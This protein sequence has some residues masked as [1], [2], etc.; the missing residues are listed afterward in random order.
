QAQ[1]TPGRALVDGARYIR[2]WGETVR[3]AARVHTIGGLSAHAGQDS[4]FAWYQ[5]FGGPPPVALVHGEPDASQAL[6]GLLRRGGAA[7]VT[8]PSYGDA[9]ELAELPTSPHS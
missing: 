7:R 2:L 5:Q 1:G 6:A 9:I 4:L 8:I 3:V